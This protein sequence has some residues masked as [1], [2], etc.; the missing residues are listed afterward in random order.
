MKVETVEK[1]RLGFLIFLCLIVLM[2]LI[3]NLSA[4]GQSKSL[5]KLGKW[6]SQLRYDQGL[7]LGAEHEFSKYGSG[8][9]SLILGYSL[10]N[11]AEFGAL[12]SHSQF[13]EEVSHTKMMTQ[14]YFNLNAFNM[15]WIGGNLNFRLTY[16][17]SKYFPGYG[18]FKA[19]EQM[20]SCGWV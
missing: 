4:F 1:I 7:V 8:N 11:G 14:V 20:F 19:R 5:K 18:D 13:F 12:V 17:D 16:G 2:I 6:H 9:T 3:S 15:P 10:K